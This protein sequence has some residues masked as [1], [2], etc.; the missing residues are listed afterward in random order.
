MD[1]RGMPFEKAL[2]VD[3]VDRVP[4]SNPQEALPARPPEARQ[5]DDARSAE[6]EHRPRPRHLALLKRKRTLVFF[7]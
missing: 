4:R 5:P 3:P 1:V 6:L 7:D 2:D